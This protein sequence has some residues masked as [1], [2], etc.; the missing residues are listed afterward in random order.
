MG[1]A[2]GGVSA[3]QWRAA[4]ECDGRGVSRVRRRCGTAPGK[5]PSMG[6][7]AES[8]H[9]AAQG[10]TGPAIG[11]DRGPLDLAR[12]RDQ[13]EHIMASSAFLRSDRGRRFLRYV[14]QV[15]IGR[16][17]GRERAYTYVDIPVD[18]VTT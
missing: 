13:P 5:G 14:A 17:S 18:A 2:T 3:A 16:G 6:L 7:E 10:T 4:D 8:G 11:R 1:Q 15:Q 12:I 9:S